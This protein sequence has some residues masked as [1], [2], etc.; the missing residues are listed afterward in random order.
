MAQEK[1]DI[2]FLLAPAGVAEKSRLAAASIASKLDENNAPHEEIKALSMYLQQEITY[3]KMVKQIETK[4][5]QYAKRQ[6][7]WLKRDK[8]IEWFPLSKEEDIMQRIEKFLI[9]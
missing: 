8:E 4:S 9:E 1:P 5:R 3:D 2:A 7:T 6:M